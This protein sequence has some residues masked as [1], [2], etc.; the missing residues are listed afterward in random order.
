MIT[1]GQGSARPHPE[2]AKPEAGLRLPRQPFLVGRRAQGS[3]IIWF[4]QPTPPPLPGPWHVK[5]VLRHT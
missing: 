1:S 5:A 4:L 2:E 3:S